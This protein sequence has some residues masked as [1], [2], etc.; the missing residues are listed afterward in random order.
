MRYK[1]TTNKAERLKDCKFHIRD[2][3]TAHPKGETMEKPIKT[4]TQSK[5]QSQPRHKMNSQDTRGTAN[6]SQDTKEQPIK[7]K[8]KEHLT[9]GYNRRSTQSQVKD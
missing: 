8:H 1:G 3:G 4:K 7:A 6:H 5:S 2:K 9:T